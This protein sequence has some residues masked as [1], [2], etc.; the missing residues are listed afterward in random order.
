M[1]YYQNP[2]GIIDPPERHLIDFAAILLSA[3]FIS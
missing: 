3:K 2:L 1:D